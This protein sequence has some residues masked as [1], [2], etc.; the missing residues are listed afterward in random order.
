[1]SGRKSNELEKDLTEWDM[2]NSHEKRG[3]R[4]YLR[5]SQR[6]GGGSFYWD[7]YRETV[8]REIKLDMG[9]DRT[10]ERM[11]RSQKFR[12]CCQS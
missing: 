1:M 2:S 8:W 10:S 3:M 6:E 12:T 4:S 5:G 9:E 7:S 11:R